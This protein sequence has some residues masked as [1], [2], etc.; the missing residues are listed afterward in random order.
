MDGLCELI[1][2]APV[3]DALRAQIR[4]LI[5]RGSPNRRLPPIL[6][7]GETGTGKNLVARVIHR[8][9]PRGAGPLVD[10]NCAAIPRDLLEAELFGFERGA[11][12]DAR[13]PKAGLF[14]SAHGGTILLDEIALL[15]DALQAKLLNVIEEPRGRR[16]GRTRGEP[17]DISI[18]AAT[19]EDLVAAVRARRFREDLY[20]RLAVVTLRLPSLRERRDDIP[21]LAEHFLTLAFQDYGLSSKGLTSRARAAL[22]AHR[23]PGNV[24]ELANVME[25][26]VLLA[27]TSHIDSDTLELLTEPAPSQGAPAGASVPR[28][29][30]QVE[31][32]EREQVLH[33][34][35]ATR[36]NVVRAAVRLGI[37]RAM[38]RHRMVK[39]ELAAPSRPARRRRSPAVSALPPA[40]PAVALPPATLRW[41]PRLAALLVAILDSSNA[42][43]TR[44]Q[45]DRNFALVVQ[46]VESFTGRIE[47]V[48]AS[49][50]LAAFGVA[51][52]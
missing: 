44:A 47:D 41:G 2:Q 20:H 40:A 34:L 35:E 33:A 29:A 15:S 28:L 30:A 36:W 16:L 27:E 45:L 4:H 9:G 49:R 31:G 10:V 17:V 14:Q 50:I 3:M 25:R 13:Q 12:T 32:L 23:W 5:A 38:I 24:R 46:K 42:E 51:P 11:F 19:N 48:G 18:I 8:A 43:R 39:Y 26:A 21:M 6:L 1:R 37:T 7:Q 52:G 22:C